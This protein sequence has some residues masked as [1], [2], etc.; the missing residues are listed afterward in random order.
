MSF[1]NRN[2]II[3]FTNTTLALFIANNNFVVSC[4]RIKCVV[5]FIILKKNRKIDSEHRVFQDVEIIFFIEWQNKS[6]CIMCK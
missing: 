4:Y 2:N 3:V 5:Q 6:M 1:N